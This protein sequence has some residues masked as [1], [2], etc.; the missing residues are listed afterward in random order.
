MKPSSSRQYSQ[1]LNWLKDT[2][3]IFWFANVW[4]Q[5]CGHFVALQKHLGQKSR[6]LLK[7]SFNFERFLALYQQNRCLI[8]Y[9]PWRNISPTTLAKRQHA[10]CSTHPRCMAFGSLVLCAWAG[11]AF[12][13]SGAT[14]QAIHEEG[15][16]SNTSDKTHC[17]KIFC[18]GWDRGCWYSQMG[19]FRQKK[20]SNQKAHQGKWKTHHFSVHISFWR[21]LLSH[22]AIRFW[23]N[24]PSW[25]KWNCP[26]SSRGLVSFSI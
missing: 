9:V 21:W 17:W 6:W 11:W 22:N 2:S 19:H 5:Y 16:A 15:K 3:I 14:I 20:S 8:S 7:F 4:C 1:S 13:S 23:H 10:L 24:L 18:T 12:Q 26:L 25:H